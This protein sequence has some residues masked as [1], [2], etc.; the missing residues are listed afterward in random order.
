MRLYFKRAPT[1]RSSSVETPL[2][3]S[4]TITR[5]YSK[6]RVHANSVSSMRSL[7]LQYFLYT[8]VSLGTSS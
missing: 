4:S 1:A 3:C 2:A 7:S 5:L 8:I 6:G